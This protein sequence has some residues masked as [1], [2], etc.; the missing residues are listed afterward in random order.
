MGFTEDI[1]HQYHEDSYHENTLECEECTLKDHS[2]KTTNFSSNFDFSFDQ[3][4][5]FNDNF[6]V[7][8]VFSLGVAAYQSQ[9]P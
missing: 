6:L 3:S 4:F 9:A 5:Q 1:E 8:D 7:R 2:T